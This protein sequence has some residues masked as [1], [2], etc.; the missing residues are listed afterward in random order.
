MA[1][2]VFVKRCLTLSGLREPGNPSTHWDNPN[3]HW[4][5]EPLA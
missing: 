4:D 1:L 5:W 3:A 2:H